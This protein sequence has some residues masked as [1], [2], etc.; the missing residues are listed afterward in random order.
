M[1]KGAGPVPEAV[2]L[3][4]CALGS[5]QTVTGARPKAPL[6]RSANQLLAF[7]LGAALIC[8]GT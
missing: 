3:I 2:D 5:G 7:S 6:G 1:A 4:P 8:G